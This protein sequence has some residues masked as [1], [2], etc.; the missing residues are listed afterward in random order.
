MA[1]TAPSSAISRSATSVSVEKG[2]A[3]VI[4]DNGA[5]G[6]NVPYLDGLLAL[7]TLRELSIK[8]DEKKLFQ[9]L[10]DNETRMLKVA[11]STLANNPAL[12]NKMGNTLQSVM[13][14]SSVIKQRRNDLVYQNILDKAVTDEGPKFALKTPAQR[15]RVI[16]G[17][18]AQAALRLAADPFRD[19]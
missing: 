7:K 17:D 3:N 2:L 5:D 11:A 9:D 18:P 19:F 4:A 10:I 14:L 6:Q 8:D 16:N 1:Q 15:L 12:S 13:A